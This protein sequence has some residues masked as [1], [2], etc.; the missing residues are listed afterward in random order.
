[1]KASLRPLIL[2][3]NRIA[4]LDSSS[5]TKLQNL[6]TRINSTNGKN[7]QTLFE[8]FTKQKKKQSSP[9]TFGF[10]STPLRTTLSHVTMWTN[11][12]EAACQMK[13]SP[14]SLPVVTNWSSP[15]NRASFKKVF[16]FFHSIVRQKKYLPFQNRIFFFFFFS[17]LPVRFLFL[18]ISE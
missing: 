13:S 3:Q 16:F 8:N 11:S 2:T 9:F 17:S 12:P 15:R 7:R 6:D 5:S 14:V 18:C 10:G 4:F 1:M